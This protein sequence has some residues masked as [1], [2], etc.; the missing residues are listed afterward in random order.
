VDLLEI[1]GDVD[2]GTGNIDA[3]GCV[4]VRGTVRGKFRV[5]AKHDITVQAS[6]EDAIVEAGD[7][8]H[9]GASILGGPQGRVAAGSRISVKFAQNANVT[10]GGDV[11]IRDSD[12]N[13]VIECRGRLLATEARG[14]LRGGSYTALQGVRVRELG[15]ALGAPTIVSV[16]TDP[17]L[18]RELREVQEALRAVEEKE[19]KIQR[20]LGASTSHVRAPQGLDARRHVK[21]RRE[22]VSSEASL[23]ARKRQL[24]ERLFAGAPPTVEVLGTVHAGVDIYIRGAHWRTQH[25]AERVRFC[26]DPETHDIRAGPL[27]PDPSPP[28]R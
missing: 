8:L 5:T 6:I 22:L 23:K 20:S 2:Y 27:S 1:A 25:A 19:R 9:V 10:C 3:T 12:T 13:S 16:G 18:A 14:V 7:T 21:A 15:S 4:L 26:Y 17:A 24:E 11:E 28:M